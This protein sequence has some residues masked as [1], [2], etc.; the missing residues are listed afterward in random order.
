MGSVPGKAL[1]AHA[2]FHNLTPSLP[3]AYTFIHYS[4]AIPESFVGF[5]LIQSDYASLILSKLPVRH[6]FL[7]AKIWSLFAQ[8]SLV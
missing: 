7:Q 2:Q 1:Q 3:M 4:A 8:G 5:F 6:H